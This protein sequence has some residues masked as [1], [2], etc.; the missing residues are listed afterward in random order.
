MRKKFRAGI[1]PL[2]HLLVTSQRKRGCGILV[3]ASEYLQQNIYNKNIYNK[4]TCDQDIDDQDTCDQDI[5]NKEDNMSEDWKDKN[6]SFFSHT[7]CEYFP[8]HKTDKPEDFNCL[9]CYC[10]LYALK[11]KCGGNFKYHD[12]IKDCSDCLVPHKRG[13]YGYIMS[14][15]GELMKLAKIDK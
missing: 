3:S 4:N 9:F 8:C 10:P 6:Y 1:P 11:D 5:Y 2:L 15:Y 7:K 12:G 13:N 14:K